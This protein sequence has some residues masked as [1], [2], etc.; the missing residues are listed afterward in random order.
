VTP[1]KGAYV[2]NIGDLMQRWSNN[3]YK[4][5]MHRVISPASQTDRY[6]C[7]FFN[8]GALDVIVE[9]L[10]G[11]VKAGEKPIYPP[12]KVEQ[13]IVN[14]YVQSYGAAGTVLEAKA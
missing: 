7:A 4:S 14:R 6:S 2:C 10:P 11:T 3:R 5:T 12:L 13:H 1:I 9:A 8:D